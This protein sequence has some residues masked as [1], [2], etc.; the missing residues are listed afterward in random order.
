MY[1]FIHHIVY[2]FTILFRNRK[3]FLFDFRE[4][5]VD[6]LNILSIRN[7]SPWVSINTNMY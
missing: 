1:D 6:V 4:D 3:I 5:R 2:Y 7:T